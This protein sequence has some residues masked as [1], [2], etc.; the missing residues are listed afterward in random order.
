[1]IPEIDA[2]EVDIIQNIALVKL[3]GVEYE[4]KYPAN[5]SEFLAIETFKKSYFYL[6]NNSEPR[7]FHKFVNEGYKRMVLRKELRKYSSFALLPATL[8]IS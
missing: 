6:K 5:I 7:L 1:M 2:C 4:V 3:E 8:C